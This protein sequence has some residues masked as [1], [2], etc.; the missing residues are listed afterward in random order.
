MDNPGLGLSMSFIEGFQESSESMQTVNNFV[1]AFIEF[2]LDLFIMCVCL[3]LSSL[4]LFL[5]VCVC[6]CVHVHT[7]MPVCTYTEFI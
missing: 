3:C 1:S 2:F 4:C 6:A 7:C 5:A